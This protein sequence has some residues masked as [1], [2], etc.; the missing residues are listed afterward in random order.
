MDLLIHKDNRNPKRA[1][2]ATVLNSAAMA[3]QKR[4]G[5]LEEGNTQAMAYD[6]SEIVQGAEQGTHIEH[7]SLPQSRK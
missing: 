5:L 7:R 6:C 3:T 4:G 1:R 2:E